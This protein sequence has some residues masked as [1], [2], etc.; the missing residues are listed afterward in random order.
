MNPQLKVRLISTVYSFLS[1]VIMAVAGV[2]VSPDFSVLVKA[3]FG[4]S[5][6]VGFF[7]L[8]MPELAKA[9]R[10]YAIL[11]KLGSAKEKPFLI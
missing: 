2:F 4:N 1:L 8:L 3:N 7:L 11:N 9:I 6:L 10:N 5:A